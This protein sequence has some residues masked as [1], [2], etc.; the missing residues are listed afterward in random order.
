MKRVIFLAAFATIAVLGIYYVITFYDMNL[1][2]GRMANTSVVR[3]HEEPLLLMESGTVPFKG[4]EALLKA[5]LSSGRPTAKKAPSPAMVTLGEKE[6]QVFCSH[7]HGE[8]MDGFGT[9]GQSFNPLPT[10]LLSEQVAGKSDGDLF[11]H[12]SYGGERSPALATSMSEESRWAVISFLR[13]R[14]AANQ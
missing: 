6:Y 8:K 10:D 11:L 4:G 5:G 2:W 12:I 1:K 3:P 7:C 13:A 14:Q 9:V